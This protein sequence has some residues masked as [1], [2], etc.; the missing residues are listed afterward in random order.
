MDVVRGVSG[1]WDAKRKS[2][3]VKGCIGGVLR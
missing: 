2:L 3:Q 1:W